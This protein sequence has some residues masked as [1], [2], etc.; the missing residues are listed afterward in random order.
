MMTREVQ[1]AY[2]AGFFDGEGHIRIQ[3]HSKR[4]SYMLSVSAVQATPYPLP[5][6]VELFGGTMKKRLLNYRGTKRALFTWQTS[7]ACA[8]RALREM[9]PFLIVKRD[10]AEVALRFRATF[11]PQHGER[12]KN[13]P[14]VELAREE[15]MRLLQSMRIEKRAAHTAG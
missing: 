11:R 7:S 12:S 15:M 1:V 6:F 5:L 9:M 10:E 8:E 14:E 13:S 3:S 4:G 2:A